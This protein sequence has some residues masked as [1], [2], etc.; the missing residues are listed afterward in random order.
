[1]KNLDKLGKNYK[2]DFNPTKEN[3]LEI[4]K[5]LIEEENKTKEGFYCNWP[6]IHDSFDKKQIVAL[7]E[8][9]IAIGFMTYSIYELIVTIWITEIKPEK[10]K[11]GLGGFLLDEF[12]KTLLKK[13]IIAAKL[14]CS[15]IS[16]EKIWR[17][18]NFKNYPLF[19]SEKRIWM[20]RTFLP[21]LNSIKDS[22]QLTEVI[23][24]WE[25]E[26]YE[27]I[28]TKPKWVWEI[29]YQK[30]SRKLSL[31]IIHPVYY[32][33]QLC[34]KIGDNIFFKDRIENFNQTKILYGDF[35]IIRE[36]PKK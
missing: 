31:P 21:F 27:V 2:I 16:S 17:K 8:N 14:Y 13:R 23:Q 36:L 34:W 22:D 35:V 29:S 12:T 30:N 26:S 24:L 33:W 20:Y 11:L 6:S 25:G 32:K 1:M 19:P 3:L 4:E 15:P 5:W 9:G 7:L 18:L 28:N 10:R